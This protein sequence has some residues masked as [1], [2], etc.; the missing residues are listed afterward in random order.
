M[1][2]VAVFGAA[3]AGALLFQVVALRTMDAATVGSAV[4]AYGVTS[5]GS[6]VAGFGLSQYLAREVARERSWLGYRRSAWL[7]TSVGTLPFAIG[8]ATVVRVAYGSAQGFGLRAQVLL[9]ALIVTA[10]LQLL[11]STFRRA[12]GRILS[13]AVL[14]QGTL[15]FSAVA[16]IPV[17]ALFGRL[18]LTQVLTVMLG[19]QCALLCAALPGNVY[20]GGQRSVKD[21]VLQLRPGGSLCA[22]LWAAT[23][24]TM[25]FR[26][27]D[28]LLVAA[29]LSPA[30][31]AQYQSLFVLTAGFD[32][33]SVA[34]GYIVLP[35]Y[36]TLG[37]WDRRRGTRS[38]A[39]LAALGALVTAAAAMLVGPTLLQLEWDTPTPGVLV[40]L[41]CV[42]VLKI[43]YADFSSAVGGTASAGAIGRFT[44][45]MGGAFVL[46]V[47][48]T[49]VIA[50]ADIDAT[51][52]VSIGAVCA[53]AARTAIAGFF[54]NKME[55]AGRRAV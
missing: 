44:S 22:A 51:I 55:R 24:V 20:D 40:L 50:R 7:V 21:L 45:Y 11:E 29:L 42:G 12:T 19:V 9:A 13:G 35:R 5:V 1:S 27:F 23:S 28:R 18:N 53:W 49:L 16:L 36:A 54:A 52:A 33:L 14:V 43:A 6:T 34:H 41:T 15:L 17:H 10:A 32:V 38:I 8:A 31:L 48:L 37:G 26:W 25:A 3:G 2:A 30:V 4:L 46:S 39:V 47:G